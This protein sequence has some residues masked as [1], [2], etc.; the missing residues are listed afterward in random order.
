[1][2]KGSKVLAKISETWN[3]LNIKNIP[4]RDILRRRCVAKISETWNGLNI[5]IIPAWDIPRHPWARI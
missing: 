4:A 2:D 1:V 5:K 3:G